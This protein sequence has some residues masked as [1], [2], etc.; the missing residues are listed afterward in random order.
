MKSLLFKILLYIVIFGLFDDGFVIAQSNPRPITWKDVPAWKS[1]APN[2]A[3]ISPDGKWAA[4]AIVPVDGDGDLYLQ[5]VGD[6]T[7]KKYPIGGTTFPSMQFSKDGKWFAFKEAAKNKDLKAAAKPGGKQV[8]DKLILID[9]AN[10]KKTE[11]EKVSSYDF[12]GEAATHLGLVM[13][14][15]RASGAPGGAAGPKG[16]DFLLLELAS[17]KS[18]NIG[19]VSEFKFN[20]AGNWLALT[21]DAANQAGNGI[22]LYNIAAKQTTIIESDKATYQSLNWTEAGDAFAALKMVK[23]EKYKQDHGRVVGVKNLGANPTIAVYD[24][25][26][27]SLSFPKGK[28]IS[29]N[30]SP[31]W[32]E[33]LTRLLF[34]IHEQEL[35]KKEPEK[36]EEAISENKDSLQK[37]EMDKLVKLKS[38]TSIKSVADM[39]KAISK[40]DPKVPPAEKIDTVK[41]DMTIWH[42][43]DKRLQARQQ[44]LQQQDKNFFYWGMYDTRNQKMVQLNDSSVRSLSPMPKH[45]YAI[46]TDISEYELDI[47]LD[48]QSYQDVFLVD[49]NTGKAEKILEKFYL[50]SFASYPRSSPDGMKWIYGKDGHYY[51]YDIFARTHTN[52]T[53]AVPTSFINTEDDHNVVKPLTSVLDWSNDSRFV[54]IRDLWDIWQVPVNGKDKA[55]NLTQNGRQT[56]I[57]YQTRFVLDQEEKGI[58]LTKPMYVRMYGERTKKSGIGLI[59]A[60]AKTGVK[61]RVQPLIWEDASVSR[62][63]KADKADVYVFSRE[64][65]TKP[66]EFY[67]STGTNL[68]DAKQITKNA[69]DAAKYTWSKGVR[70]VNYVSDKGD[71]LQGALFLPANYEEGKKYPALVYYYEKLSQTLHNWSNPGFSGTGWNPSMYTSNGYAVFIPDIVYTIDDPGMSAVWCVLPAVKEAIKT[72]VIDADKIGI[73]GHSWGG[74]QTSFLITQTNMFKAAAAGAP[75]TNMVSMYDLIYWNSGSGNMSIFEASQGRFKGAPWEN[76]DSYLRNSP[77][78][79]VKKVATPL[80]ML[81]NDKDG[82][83]DFTQGIEYY[84][85]LR[86]LK[87]PVVMMQYKGENHGLSKLENRKDYAVRMMEFF[88]YYLKGAPAPDWWTDGVDHLKLSEHLDKRVF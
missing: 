28:T 40:L 71:S 51:I 79:H 22:Q 80:L 57:R 19:N 23:D 12:N 87:K 29:P 1:L 4:Y 81:H 52:I 63:T 18:Q 10:D 68:I 86:R 66:T 38:D 70:L 8:F 32:T 16:G 2:G 75:L 14:K 59:E 15:D 82:A 25:K 3:V 20:K 27:D 35:A 65:F 5:R 64:T 61:P 85:A 41:P 83:V 6:T 60:S 33:D 34:G 72:G 13:A 44:V 67:A 88:D 77:V 11:F 37:A 30:R 21:I 84:N 53:L 17:G 50:P 45:K 74:Y 48:G 9:L 54:L 36:K 69:P 47:N 39:Q 26:K 56:G 55:V 78:Y 24:P 7:L 76:W 62:L 73:H 31:I 43:K 42:W 58:D 46:A 49:L